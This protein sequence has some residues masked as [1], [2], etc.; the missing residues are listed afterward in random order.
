MIDL[1]SRIRHKHSRWEEM[2]VGM[3]RYF[4]ILGGKRGVTVLEKVVFVA[5]FSCPFY[6]IANRTRT[7]KKR[8]KKKRKTKGGNT[9]PRAI[10]FRWSSELDR[11][12][13][14]VGS[15]ISPV[16]GDLASH[17]TLSNVTKRCYHKRQQKQPIQTSL[18]VIL[19]TKTRHIE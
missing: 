1:T 15:Y 6:H 4:E 7:P 18:C 5:V 10:I 17:S 19:S 2:S 12:S 9:K 14:W 3:A 8:K 13:W 11:R 16:P